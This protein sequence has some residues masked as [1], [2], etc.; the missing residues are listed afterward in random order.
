[1]REP[2]GEQSGG[3]HEQATAS[4]RAISSSSDCESGLPPPI[5]SKTRLPISMMRRNQQL[6]KCEKNSGCDLRID[7]NFMAS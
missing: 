4:F 3:R 7:G 1:M 6:L 5:L 2:N